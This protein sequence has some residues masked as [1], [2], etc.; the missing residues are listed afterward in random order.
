MANES[1]SESDSAPLERSQAVW[2]RPGFSK[3]L[4]LLKHQPWL[5][6]K[7]V[8]LEE[9]HNLCESDDE[10]ELILDLL[11][12]FKYIQSESRKDCIEKIV[13]KIVNGWKLSPDDTVVVSKDFEDQSPDSSQA[14]NVLLQ[15]FFSDYHSKGWS[16]KNFSTKTREALRNMAFKNLVLVDDFSGSGKS[17]I[18]FLKWIDD[19]CTKESLPSRK[20]YTCFF[21]AMDQTRIVVAP[22]L[23]NR[24]FA[25]NWL[26]RGI[27]DYEGAETKNKQ[28]IMKR[29]EQELDG[30]KPLYS[31]GF[32]QCETLYACEDFNI[33]NNNF[34]IFWYDRVGNGSYRKPLFRRLKQI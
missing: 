30:L 28:R 3:T 29:I 33:P 13:S 15:P 10:L 6:N 34:P 21:S 17:V 25:V 18:K 5:H 26:K 23:G 27:T 2:A 16:K 9:L 7:H 1:P 32:G 22:K 12:R 14:V 19:F 4:K 24:L 31:L 20:I 8:A 11:F